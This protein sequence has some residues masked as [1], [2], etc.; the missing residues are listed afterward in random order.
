MENLVGAPHCHRSRAVAYSTTN[1]RLRDSASIRAAV[2]R[3]HSLESPQKW[4]PRPAAG[5]GSWTS[6][7]S[8][9]HTGCMRSTL[10]RV[11]QA[12]RRWLA[13]VTGLVA[14]G[15]APAASAAPP[16]VGASADVDL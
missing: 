6:T 15:A 4:S 13:V 1:A 16:G 3:V 9:R 2:R 10:I 5:I 7:V 11:G 12:K 14:L 8:Q